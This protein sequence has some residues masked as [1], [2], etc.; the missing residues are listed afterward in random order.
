MC[1]ASLSGTLIFIWETDPYI[2]I[3]DTDIILDS[4]EANNSYEISLREHLKILYKAP[5]MIIQLQQTKVTSF[6]L[7]KSIKTAKI[8]QYK[9]T[10]NGQKLDLRVMFGSSKGLFSVPKSG[11]MMYHKNRLIKA[12]EKISQ[13]EDEL[14]IIGIV[15][16]NEEKPNH[17]KTDFF[18]DARFERILTGLAYRLKDYIDETSLSNFFPQ[19]SENDD[20]STWLQC[21]KCG[22]WRKALIETKN[23]RCKEL[24]MSCEQAQDES[25]GISVPDL[26]DLYEKSTNLKSDR[27]DKKV[28]LAKKHQREKTSRDAVRKRNNMQISQIITKKRDNFKKSAKKMKVEWNE[29]SPTIAKVFENEITDTESEN[30]SL[31]EKIIETSVKTPEK[32]EPVITAEHSPDVIVHSPYEID[33]GY[34]EGLI[35]ENPS[36]DSVEQ[37]EEVFRGKYIE[38]AYDYISIG[39]CD[40]FDSVYS[41]IS[42]DLNRNWMCLDVMRDDVDGRPVKICFEEKDFKQIYYFNEKANHM[43]LV[44]L[45]GDY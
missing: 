40:N 18:H 14:E 30:E 17:S 6:L 4:D 42:I 22:K 28:A 43:I 8:Y 35:F 26:A 41:K 11:F 33:S 21:E 27:L 34:N 16:L 13:I 36:V 2:R 7:Q 32:E 44:Q 29:S 19:N 37:E 1:R 38:I 20:S 39:R 23:F 9:T 25:V 45:K 10:V 31:I 24:K 15:D 3:T 5:K 12:F